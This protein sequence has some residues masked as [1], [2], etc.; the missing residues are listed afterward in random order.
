MHNGM[1][2]EVLTRWQ[3]W[4]APTRTSSSMKGPKNLSRCATWNG[5]SAAIVGV[6]NL[7]GRG[8]GKP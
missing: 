4:L 8:V 5:L 2:G 3:N 7:L 6:P 1:H